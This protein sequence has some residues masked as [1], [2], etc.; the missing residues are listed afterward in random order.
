[1]VL[2][3]TLQKHTGFHKYVN[4][5]YIIKHRKFIKMQDTMVDAIS[6]LAIA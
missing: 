4:I 6:S 5:I 3:G 2:D 1:M